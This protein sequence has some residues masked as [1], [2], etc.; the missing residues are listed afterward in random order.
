MN[1][2]ETIPMHFGRMNIVVE[3]TNENGQLSRF[4]A[5]DISLTFEPRSSPFHA[6]T[7]IL[8]RCCKEKRASAPGKGYRN[9]AL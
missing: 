5:V 9:I 1:A 3:F 7:T 4:V 2:K 8:L 6:N